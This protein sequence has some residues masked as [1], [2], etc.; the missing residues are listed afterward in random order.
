MSEYDEI[1]IWTGTTSRPLRRGD[2]AA[3]LVG[4]HVYVGEVQTMP[5][6]WLLL[7]R[8]GDDPHDADQMVTLRTSRIEAL[9]AG[10]YRY[11][12]SDTKQRTIDRV[13]AFSREAL[14]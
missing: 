9:V 6:E 1:P 5:D 11:A 10:P 12:L 2:V 8:S 3:V 4:G 7:D 13:V 14:R